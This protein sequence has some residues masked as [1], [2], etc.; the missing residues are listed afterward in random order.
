MRA[1]IVPKGHLDHCY[2][3]MGVFSGLSKH[4]VMAGEGEHAEV[5]K[6]P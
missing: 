1:E 4:C 6:S 5:S 2:R 3:S